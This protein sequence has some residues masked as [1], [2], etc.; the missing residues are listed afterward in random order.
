MAQIKQ[1]LTVS[2]CG[3]ITLTLNAPGMT[4][5]V[6]KEP[7]KDPETSMVKYVY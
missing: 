1:V 6:V 2:D 7:K 4:T 3:E 5:L